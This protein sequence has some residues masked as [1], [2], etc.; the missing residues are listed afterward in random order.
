[1]LNKIKLRKCNNC[2]IPK[3]INEFYKDK[4][5]YKNGGLKI[6]RICK[7]CSKEKVKEWVKKNKARKRATWKR[8]YERNKNNENYKKKKILTQRIW[9]ANHPDYNYH[10]FLKKRELNK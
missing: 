7:S 8:W 2:L 1:M 10:S 9:R 3:P 6:K 5:G 4:K